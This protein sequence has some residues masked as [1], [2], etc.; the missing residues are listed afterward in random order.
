MA[1]RK[2]IPKSI[3]FEVFKR[4]RFTCQY[5]GKS[6]PNAVLHV[7]HIQPV[8]KDGD[9]EITNL[10][11]ACAEC[12]GGKGARELS[13]SAI[14]EKKKAQLD[15]LQARREQLELMFMWQQG[16]LDLESIQVEKVSEIYQ[17]L[18]PGW[19]WNESGLNLIKR[20]INRFG[21]EEVIECLRISASQ[22]LK[23]VDGRPEKESVEKTTNYIEKIANMRRKYR[24]DPQLETIHLVIRSVKNIIGGNP[25]YYANE[26]IRRALNKGYEPGELIGNAYACHSYSRWLENIESWEE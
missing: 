13:D 26:Y 17:E 10:I 25:P 5:C 8:S 15:E 18:V 23:F 20:L 9:N 22:Y 3:R 24:A 16:L 14:M 12:N 1:E 7:D 19:S 11:T 4:D 21:F 2:A 6:A